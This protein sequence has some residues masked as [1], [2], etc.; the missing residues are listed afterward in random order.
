MTNIDTL[1]LILATLA[2]FG[3]CVLAILT[4]VI[5]VALAYLVFMFGW[6][7][8]INDQSLMLGG[9]YL[10]KT[11][12]AGYNRWRSQKWNMENRPWEKL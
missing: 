2:T 3:A 10:R 6:S 7:Q 8:V 11:P 9:Y 4:A 5:A 12:V 1:N